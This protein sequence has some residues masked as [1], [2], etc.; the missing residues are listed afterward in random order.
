MG[1]IVD[2]NKGGVKTEYYF[3]RKKGGQLIEAE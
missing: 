3:V 1:Y 2:F